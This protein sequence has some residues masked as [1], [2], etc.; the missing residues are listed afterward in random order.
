MKHW[1]TTELIGGITADELARRTRRTIDAARS[2]ARR[3]GIEL[4]PKRRGYPTST[5]DRALRMRSAGRTF[6]EIAKAT[7]ASERTIQNWVNGRGS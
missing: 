3:H 7:G 5:R 1:R 4:K 2:A 6:A